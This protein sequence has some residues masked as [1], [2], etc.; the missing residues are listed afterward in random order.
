MESHN[1]LVS[2]LILVIMLKFSPFSLA[3]AN[4]VKDALMGSGFRDIHIESLNL[5]LYLP[6]WNSYCYQSI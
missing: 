3:N 4:I 6:C 1:S 5:L 2:H